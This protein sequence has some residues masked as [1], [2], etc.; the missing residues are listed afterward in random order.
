MIVVVQVHKAMFNLNVFSHVNL[1]KTVVPHWLERR[2]GHVVVLSSCASKIALP[3]SAT[4]NATKAALHDAVKF[5]LTEEHQRSFVELKRRL[6]TTLILGN[7]DQFAEIEIHT[8]ASNTGHGAVL[9]QMQDRAERVI[10]Y[11]SPML[12]KAQRNYSTTEKECLAVV[13]AITKFRPYLY[14][15][16]FRVVTDH[17]SLCWLANL[18]DPSG[19]LA[20]WSLRL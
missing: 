9:V 18:K 1:T 14:G 17:H 11:A 8:D 3:D 15:S 7:F 19:S 20:R 12:S 2:T 4:Y 10:A 6:H 16:P 13:W 5:E